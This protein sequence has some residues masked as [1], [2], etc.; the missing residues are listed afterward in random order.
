MMGGKDPPSRP[1]PEPNPNARVRALSQSLARTELSGPQE[2][3]AYRMP[4]VSAFLAHA[5][6]HVRFYKDR[7]DFDV[8][9]PQDI[10][11]AWSSIPILT[12]AQAVEHQQQLICERLPADAGRVVSKQTSGSTGIALHYRSASL[13]DAW[14]CALSERMF[15]WWRVDGKRALAMITQT[16]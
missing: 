12:R 15:R 13:F 10:R 1:S 3:D 4:F 14:N 2:L 9:S 8:R 7:L 16:S 5:R 11:N 6:D